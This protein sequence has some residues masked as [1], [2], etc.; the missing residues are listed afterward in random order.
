MGEVVLRYKREPGD[1]STGSIFTREGE[2]VQVEF[3]F[4]HQMFRSMMARFAEILTANPHFSGVIERNDR[5]GLCPLYLESA[6]LEALR[7]D[8]VKAIQSLESPL[9]SVTDTVNVTSSASLQARPVRGINVGYDTFADAFGDILYCRAR[10][11]EDCQHQLECPGCGCWTSVFCYSDGFDF[12]CRNC[13]LYL[14]CAVAGTHWVTVE[15]AALLATKTTTT[16]RFFF[17][18]VWNHS[19]NPWISRE[20]LQKKYSAW[21]EE[22]KHV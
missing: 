22:K 8:P 11:Q 2:R 17:P 20:E 1:L 21:L 7:T 9:R 10:M 3:E 5:P 4:R 12:Q 14:E 16:P 18:R 15:T 6:L 19:S 13:G